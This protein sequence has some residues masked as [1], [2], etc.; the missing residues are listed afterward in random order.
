M[1]TTEKLLDQL[2]TSREALLVAIE[3][4]PD[5]ALLQKG[6]VGDWSVVDVLINQTAWE[7]ELVTAFM[8]IDK[9]KRPDRLLN[10]LKNPQ[11]Y[12]QNRYI[13]TQDRDLDQVFTDLQQVR[14]QIEDWLLDF[15]GNDLS[16]PK[17]Y[18]W[19]KNK[20]LSDMIAA[21]TFDREKSFIPQLRRYAQG[22]QEREKDEAKTIIPLTAVDMNPLD[23]NYDITD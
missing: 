1:S 19:T 5:E 11:K 7:A 2:D 3:P 18:R 13:E 17:R 16:N 23:E 15:S 9:N 6:A 12:D 8:N 20:P 21:V 10:A 22:W 4:L 14:I